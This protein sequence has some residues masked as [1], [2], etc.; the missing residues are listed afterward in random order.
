VSPDHRYAAI[1][2]ENERDEDVEVVGVEGGLP[3]RPAG[4]L[5]V[6]DLT[7]G[8]PAAW[9]LRRVDLTGLSAY[10]P[11]DPEPEFVDINDDNEAV[12]TLQENNHIAIVDLKSGKVVADFPAGAVDLEGIDATEDGLIALV[13]SL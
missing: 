8:N 13:D 12:V 3:Q 7:G 4:T 9:K 6:V 10:A 5:V 2:V 11:E 1:I